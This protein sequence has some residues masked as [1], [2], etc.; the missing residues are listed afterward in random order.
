[1]ETLLVRIV[2]QS[3]LPELQK[4]NLLWH[5]ENQMWNDEILYFNDDIYFQTEYK[6]THFYC[7]GASHVL[8]NPLIVD[9]EEKKV[10]IKASRTDYVNYGIPDYEVS[11]DEFL[12]DFISGKVKVEGNDERK[13]KSYA[14]FESERIELEKKA[15]NAPER[16]KLLKFAELIDNLQR[17]EIKTDEANKI[18]NDVNTLLL[19]VTT[20]IREKTDLI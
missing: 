8:D 9:F 1:M 11:F 15:K 2:K 16:E 17:P 14:D 20:Y 18:M 7:E 4:A 12:Y 5:F 6:F 13:I 19:Q 10:T 3:G